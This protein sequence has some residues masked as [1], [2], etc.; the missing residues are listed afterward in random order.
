MTDL[1]K[2]ALLAFWFLIFVWCCWTLEAPSI[3]AEL[4]PANRTC[5]VCLVVAGAEV[6]FAFIRLFPLHGAERDP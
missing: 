3:Y 4:G 6:L 1:L 2:V 5:G